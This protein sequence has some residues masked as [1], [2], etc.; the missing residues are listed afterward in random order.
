[1][2]RMTTEEKAESY[3]AGWLEE[4][5]EHEHTAKWPAGGWSIYAECFDCGPDS[6]LTIALMND[7]YRQA[8]GELKESRAVTFY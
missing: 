6:S 2:F 4:H 5:A 3:L 1:M 8:R 7:E